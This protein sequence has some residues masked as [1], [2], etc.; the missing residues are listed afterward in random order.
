[1]DRDSLASLHDV[2]TR[3]NALTENPHWTT[4]RRWRIGELARIGLSIVNT[5]MKE[6]EHA[7]QTSVRRSDPA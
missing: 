4:D 1:M 6:K 7:P 3:I 2:L 5:E